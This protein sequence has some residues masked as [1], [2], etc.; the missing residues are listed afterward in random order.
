MCYDWL[1]RYIYFIRVPYDL[2]L[3]M[4]FDQTRCILSHIS[5]MCV[6]TKRFEKAIRQATDPDQDDDGPFH[7][8]LV[9]HLGRTRIVQ[10]VK[11][12]RHD[13][14]ARVLHLDLETVSIIGRERVTVSRQL[15]RVDAALHDMWVQYSDQLAQTLAEVAK[16][17]DEFLQNPSVSH[18]RDLVYINPVFLEKTRIRW[19]SM[20]EINDAM[21]DR[22]ADKMHGRL[23]H[24][25]GQFIQQH[26]EGKLYQPPPSVDDT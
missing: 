19:W 2:G 9:H 8:H 10:T 24:A 6:S 14:R 3:P 11:V 26:P 22:G 12:V 4:R 16:T 1:E 18:R 25:I 21:V 13:A 5:E 20:D 17:S 7:R 23:K 15:E